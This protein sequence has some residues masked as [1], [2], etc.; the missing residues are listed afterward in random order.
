MA[1]Y[2]PNAL[3]VAMAFRCL[4]VALWLIQA[5][6]AQNPR[7]GHFQIDV[8][9]P[10]DHRCMGVLPQKSKVIVDNLELHGFILLGHGQPIVVVA[11]DWCEIRNKSYDQWRSRLA[12]AAGT[13]MDRVLVSSL[14]QHDAPVIDLGA[15]ELLDKVGL[16]K[17]LY[18]PSFHED[19][20]ARAQ[21]AL[22]DAIADSQ[23]L[24]HIGYAQTAV[25]KVASNRRVVHSDGKVSFARGSSSGRD[26]WHRQA[27]EGLI[28][29]LLRTISFWNGSQCLVEYHTYA[30][31]P[32]SYYGRGEVT[33]D[34]V[35]LA[36][37]RLS[38]LDRSIHPIYAS[39][40]SGDVT[41]GKYNDGSEQ[42]REE[43]T[44]R[45]YDAMIRNRASPTM[46][47][48]PAKWSFRSLP[49]N[50]EYTQSNG[51]QPNALQ[52]ELND[53]SL[54][55]ERRILAAMGLGSWNRC[56]LDKTPIDI[57]CID[58]EIAKMI[59]FPGE[60]FVGYQ[61]IAQRIS[62]EVPVVPVGYGECWTGYVPTEDAFRD[63]FDESW[64]WVSPG[65]QRKIESV[66]NDLMTENKDAR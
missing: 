38:K 52:Q 33:S 57:P 63:G 16:Q 22:S 49:L 35:G 62:K 46:S 28:D 51:L 29:P 25:E 7:I 42:A 11:V 39:G 15:Q 13:T 37:K 44:S 56:F 17:E 60:S 55:T 45:I 61:Y 1:K 36:R 64:L 12:S 4:L 6:Y 54:P 8:T 23:P 66:L 30:T 31:H 53:S 3:F 24:T 48:R 20:L 65:S 58:F 50:L 41:A 9:I 43:L 2:D 47:N 14:H 21:T 32:M 40:C 34:F 18:D 27:D 19:V 59:L 26:P 10:I 5:C